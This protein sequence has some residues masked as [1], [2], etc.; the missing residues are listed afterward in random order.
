MHSIARNVHEPVAG[1]RP[2]YSRS[3]LFARLYLVQGN[4][5]TGF[6]KIEFIDLFQK[7]V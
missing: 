4:R 1:G 6:H 7:K 3:T 5:R 2:E